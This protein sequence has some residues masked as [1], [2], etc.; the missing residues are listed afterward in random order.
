MR[1][2]WYTGAKSLSKMGSL[3]RLITIT[4]SI[5]S[6]LVIFLLLNFKNQNAFGEHRKIGALTYTAFN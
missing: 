2:T 1:V 3:K 4:K 5:I 6:V